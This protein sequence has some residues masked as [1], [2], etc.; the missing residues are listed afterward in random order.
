MIPDVM[1]AA[2]G[3]GQLNDTG[4]MQA[5]VS[6]SG[7]LVYISGGVVPPLLYSV[8]QVDRTGRAE[9]LPIVP[10]EF[11]TLRLSP[12]G[13]RLALSTVGRERGI[14]I[15]DFAR[16]TMSKLAAAGRSSV[17]VWMP[18]G[19]RIAYGA[20]TSGPDSLHRLRADG[21]GSSELL[22]SSPRN[23]VPGA[24]TPDGRQL[25][26]YVIPAEA[27]TAA[28][29]GPSILAHDAVEKGEPRSV[30]KATGNTGGV[31]VSP[32]GRW[33][34]YHSADSGRLQIY[35]DAYPGPG[36]RFQVSN[37]GGFSPI[38]RADGRELFYMRPTGNSR[39]IGAGVIEMQMMAV[40][41]AARP[42]LTFG[43]PRQLFEGRYSVNGPARGYDVTRDG[44][45]ILLLRAHDRPPDVVTGINVVQNWIEELK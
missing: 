11:R 29:T 30:V 34:A 1:Q 8:M 38:W 36:P 21:S 10:A 4:A 20:G 41:V 15:Y 2:Y 16:E 13:T 18:D 40:P 5:S 19:E 45:R 43:T 32:D 17:P 42:A 26:Y 25:L 23:L 31:D 24:W 44:Q 22:V 7:T 28:Q 27:A 3:A 14:W 39:G 9:A 12:E 33:I 35:V 37:D 6:S